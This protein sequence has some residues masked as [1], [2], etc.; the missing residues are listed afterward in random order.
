MVNKDEYIEQKTARKTH[1]CVRAKSVEQ[2]TTSHSES[3]NIILEHWRLFYFQTAP[4]STSEDSIKGRAMAKILTLTTVI[5]T[6]SNVNVNQH[7]K[8]LGQMSF[9]SKVIDWIH[10]QEHTNTEPYKQTALLAPPKMFSEKVNQAT[11][12]AENTIKMLPMSLYLWT[13]EDDSSKLKL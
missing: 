11:S 5:L 6:R 4:T 12:D 1:Y 13:S 3:A 2:A 10:A 7:V 9:S 8:Y